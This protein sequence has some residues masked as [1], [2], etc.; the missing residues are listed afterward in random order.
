MITAMKHTHNY[1]LLSAAALA[2]GMLTAQ[3]ADAALWTPADISTSAWYDAS[4]ASTITESGG[5]VTNW[6]DKSGNG[7]NLFQTTVGDQPSLVAAGINGL[8]VI[9][10]ANRT[11]DLDSVANIDATWV[12]IVLQ[13]N[14][15]SPAFS[16]ALG[17][18]SSSGGDNYTIQYRGDQTTTPTGDRWQGGYRTNG[19]PESTSG[20][21]VITS[22]AIVVHDDINLSDFD[23]NVG[24][25]RGLNNRAWDGYIAEVIYGN[26]DLSIETELI[27]TVEG[28]L[29]HK[30]GTTGALPGDHPFKV[31]APVPE[32]GSLALLGLG[33][34]L[35][36]QRRRRG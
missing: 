5:N 12:A 17:S 24:S 7:V 10:F 19:N 11:E 30:W 27:E 2:C 8:N 14:G 4:D 36:I 1:A 33:G 35:M 15:A 34:L 31:D 9:E 16:T 21:S 28:Y 25:D 29:A 23:L 18:E 20:A 32:P 3:S 26:Q 6:A 22:P 13:Y